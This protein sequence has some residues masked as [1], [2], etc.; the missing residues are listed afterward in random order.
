MK[1]AIITPTR[2][3]LYTLSLLHKYILHQTRKPDLWIIATDGKVPEL[4]REPIEILVTQTEY[5]GSPTNSFTGNLRRAINLA[6]E[7]GADAVLIMEDDDWYAPEY[8]EKME[9]AFRRGDIIGNKP[10]KTMNIVSGI[11]KDHQHDGLIVF[12]QLGFTRSQNDLFRASVA[13]CL[14]EKIASVD[15][16]FYKLATEKGIRP[17]ILQTPQLYFGLKGI[18]DIGPKQ[19]QGFTEQHR[20]HKKYFKGHF[21][22]FLYLFS[23]SKKNHQEQTVYEKLC[24]AIGENDAAR[25]LEIITGAKQNEW[26]EFKF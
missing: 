19:S 16:R 2:N 26:G 18:Y 5:A 4:P 7:N 6:E 12:A 9:E 20:R 3:R 23:K 10:T 13:Q 17:E 22:R 8:V 14:K 1:L 11:I 21:R 25:Y 15:R 24:H